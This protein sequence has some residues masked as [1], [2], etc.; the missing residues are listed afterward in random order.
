MSAQESVGDLLA[1][2]FVLNCRCWHPQTIRKSRFRSESSSQNRLNA[3]LSKISS[4][5][6]C[7]FCV[8][9]RCASQRNGAADLRFGSKADI[10]ACPRHVRFTPKSGHPSR[11]YSLAMNGGCRQR[12][13]PVACRRAAAKRLGVL[14]RT[15][16]AS[17]YAQSLNQDRHKSFRPVVHVPIGRPDTA[18]IP[19]RLCLQLGPL[20][21]C[22][23]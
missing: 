14:L 1:L 9:G 8:S 15:D 20:G 4:L 18:R 19:D 12:G 13:R 10:G 2:S 21:R 6:T 7:N 11:R 16:S 3:V 17:G 23:L 5:I 22:I